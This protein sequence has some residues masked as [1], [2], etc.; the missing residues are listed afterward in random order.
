MIEIAE[1]DNGSFGFCIKT[2]HNRLLLTSVSMESAEKVEKM[3][4]NLN[5]HLPGK[6]LR[7]ERKTNHKGD[8]LFNVKNSEGQVIGHSELYNSEAGMQNGINNLKILLASL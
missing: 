3:I 4:A 6:R 2:E 7:Y 5:D 8:F 1:L